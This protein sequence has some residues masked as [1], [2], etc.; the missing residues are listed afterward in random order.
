MIHPAII[1]VG[2]TEERTQDCGDERDCDQ[3]IAGVK[4]IFVNRIGEPSSHEI[5]DKNENPRTSDS[6]FELVKPNVQCTIYSDG[7]YN[8]EF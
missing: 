7:R 4:V 3:A 5:V 6:V 2:S 1:P 8:S